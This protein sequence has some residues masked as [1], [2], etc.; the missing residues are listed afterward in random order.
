MQKI[1]H[2]SSN[3]HVLGCKYHFLIFYLLIDFKPFY[4][5]IVTSMNEKENGAGL[6]FIHWEKH[7]IPELSQTNECSLK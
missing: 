4:M 1:K 5:N 3:I 6:D 7:Y 2:K